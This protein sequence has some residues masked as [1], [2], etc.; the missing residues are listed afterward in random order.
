MWRPNTSFCRCWNGAA[1][2]FSFLPRLRRKF[3]IAVQADFLLVF[4]VD[5][6]TCLVYLNANAAVVLSSR[7]GL[8]SIPCSRKSLFTEGERNTR[9]VSEALGMQSESV[10]RQAS[11][12]TE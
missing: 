11:V 4:S 7:N 2:L 5:S 3:C 8:E 1:G 6:L 10:S 12:E 9:E